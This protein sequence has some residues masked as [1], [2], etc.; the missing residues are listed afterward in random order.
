MKRIVLYLDLVAPEQDE[1]LLR[2]PE[3]GRIVLDAVNDYLPEPFSLI[4]AGGDDLLALHMMLYPERY[5]RS[6]QPDHVYWDNFDSEADADYGE[7][8]ENASV[9]DIAAAV[10]AATAKAEAE[11]RESPFE[12]NSGTIEWVGTYLEQR[13]AGTS[14]PGYKS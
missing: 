14:H 2:D 10:E 13:L 11:W 3:S 6:A 9:E 12:W 5:P 1:A 4:D 8:E 7:I